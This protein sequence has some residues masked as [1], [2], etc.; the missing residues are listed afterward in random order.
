MVPA[1]LLWKNPERGL[2]RPLDAFDE[3]GAELAPLLGDALEAAERPVGQPR[4][5]LDEG[6]L[7]GD[8]PRRRRRRRRRLPLLPLLLRLL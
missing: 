5:D 3:V 8:A 4:Q 6:A 1:K 7:G 2:R